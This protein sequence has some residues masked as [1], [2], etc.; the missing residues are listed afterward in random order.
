[1]GVI[2]AKN[3]LSGPN[4]EFKWSHARLDGINDRYFG[5]F[6]NGSEC[7]DSVGG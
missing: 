5:K 2:S 3:L 6:N 7:L 1:M 4:S